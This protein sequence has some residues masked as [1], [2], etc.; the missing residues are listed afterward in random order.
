MARKSK[1]KS[2]SHETLV[3]LAEKLFEADGSGN[4]ADVAIGG[5]V[6]MQ[7]WGSPRLTGDLDLIASNDMGLDGEPLAIGGVRGE[8][9]GIPVDV[10]VRGD[11][12][13]SLYEEALDLAEEVENTAVK[14]ISPEHLAAMKMIAGRPKD[15]EDLRYLVL[16][17]EFDRKRAEKIIEE[18][19]GPYAVEELASVISEA[20]W[21]KSK[22]E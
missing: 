4:N 7:I 1:A 8:V 17:D 5:G 11:K 13:A 3:Q 19:L 22:G 15:D 18:Y 14:V 12:W 10:I 20:E 16:W 21:R 2:I 9:E 6:A